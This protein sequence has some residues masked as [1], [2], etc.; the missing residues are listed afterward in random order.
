MQELKAICDRKLA[1]YIARRGQAVWEHRRRSP[2]YVSGTLRY[3]VLKNAKFRCE[4]CGVPLTSA[5]WKWTTS[6]LVT[7]E[8]GTRSATFTAVFPLTMRV[9]DSGNRREAKVL[10]FWP[11]SRR[12]PSRLSSSRSASQHSPTLGLMGL[13]IWPSKAHRGATRP[14]SRTKARRRQPR[15]LS[16]KAGG[17]LPELRRRS[18]WILAHPEVPTRDRV[19][20]LVRPAFI[21]PETY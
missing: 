14:A 5:L 13:I 12:I 21:C 7:R 17:C 6:R 16:L 1:E 15:S 19:E 3:E 10:N 2:G 9:A 4:L 18:S 8:V 20:R 11:S